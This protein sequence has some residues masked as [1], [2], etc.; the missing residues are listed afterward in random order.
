MEEYLKQLNNKKRTNHF[1]WLSRIN[2]YNSGDLPKDIDINMV[3]S[4]ISDRIPSSFLSNVESVYI[5]ENDFLTDR[6]MD[7]IYDSGAIYI[8]PSGI[9]DEED[10]VDDIIHEIAHSLEETHSLDIYGDGQLEREF[11]MKRMQL[12]DAL[13]Q[14]KAPHFPR[15]FFLNTEYSKDFDKFLYKIVGYPLLTSLSTNVFVS[16]YGATSLREY[17]ANSFE[18]YFM[19]HH[20]EVQKLSPQAYKKITQI[21]N[22]EEEATNGDF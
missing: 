6:D 22:Q 4:A 7:A 21:I 16:P 2:V 20:E 1:L 8:R 9:I 13:R 15:D 19:G 10:L 5:G 18:K 17:F 12:Y 14:S 3:L 11:V